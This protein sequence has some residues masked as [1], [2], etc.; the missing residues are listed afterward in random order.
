MSS[1]AAAPP[2]SPVLHARELK[3]MRAEAKQQSAAASV[4]IF[5]EQCGAFEAVL[6]RFFK[7]YGSNSKTLTLIPFSIPEPP[8][9]VLSAEW[10]IEKHVGKPVYVLGITFTQPMDDEPG[11][12]EHAANWLDGLGWQAEI[13]VIFACKMRVELGLQPEE[14][15]E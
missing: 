2:S 5:Q 15:K 1:S 7:A 11:I 6:R 4:A 10:Q 8:P 13:Y 12:C 14:K 3:R 9:G